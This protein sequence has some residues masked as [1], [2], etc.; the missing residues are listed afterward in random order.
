MTRWRTLSHS[1][2][3][4]VTPS[5]SAPLAVVDRVISPCWSTSNTRL[6][7]GRCLLPPGVAAWWSRKKRQ[8]SPSASARRVAT[9]RAGSPSTSCVSASRSAVSSSSPVSAPSEPLTAT[10]PSS[11]GEACMV[12]SRS[13]SGGAS[14]AYRRQARIAVPTSAALSGYR[15][16][17]TAGSCCANR[18]TTRGDRLTQIAWTCAL[19]SR[20]SAHAAAVRGSRATRRACRVVAAARGR[21]MRARSASHAAMEVAPSTSHSSARSK[22]STAAASRASSRSLSANAAASASPSTRMSS[23]QIAEAIAGYISH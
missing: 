10:C 9:A 17:S 19:D 7:W 1:S 4:A 13:S 20:P 22:A 3:P 12:W 5:M 2:L 14:S 6:M 11:S 8:M 21:L 16:G 23:E 15:S 18:S